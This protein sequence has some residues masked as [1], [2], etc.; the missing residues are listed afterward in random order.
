MKIT[1][2]EWLALEEKAMAVHKALNEW[3]TLATE[4]FWTHHT[5]GNAPE[6]MLLKSIEDRINN[7]NFELAASLFHVQSEWTGGDS[8]SPM[9]HTLREP[10][11]VNIS[12]SFPNEQ[13]SKYRDE[14]G[15]IKIPH[16]VSR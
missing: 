3:G 13:V 10:N 14:D 1:L 11:W 5:A 16:R 2:D 4:M 7:A 9:N 6:G 8:D 12:H 15:E